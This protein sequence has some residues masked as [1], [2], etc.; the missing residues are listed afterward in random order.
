MQSNEYLWL[1]MFPK[2]FR[3]SSSRSLCYLDKTVSLIDF[4]QLPLYA[5][6]SGCKCAPKCRRLE[7][8]IQIKTFIKDD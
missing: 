4:C 3:R 6:V 7:F 8:R 1:N 2:I 5:S